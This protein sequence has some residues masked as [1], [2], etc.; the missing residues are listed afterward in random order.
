YGL[1]SES[2]Q[3]TVIAGFSALVS[4]FCYQLG[5]AVWAAGWTYLLLRRR[6]LPHVLIWSAFMVLSLALQYGSYRLNFENRTLIPSDITRVI[7]FFLLNVGAPLGVLNEPLSGMMGLVLLFTLLASIL[8]IRRNEAGLPFSRQLALALSLV[9]ISFVSSTLITLGRSQFGLDWAVQSRYTTV[10]SVGVLGIFMC[11]H[12]AHTCYSSR[13]TS[14]LVMLSSVA[15]VVG[16]GFSYVQG[17]SSGMYSWATRMMLRFTVQS[18]DFE[19]VDHRVIFHDLEVLQRRL[20]FLKKYRLGVYR[21]PPLILIP[22]Q[23]NAKPAPIISPSSSLVQTFRCPVKS[24]YDFKLPFATSGHKSTGTLQLV[25]RNG[26]ETVIS[27]AIPMEKIQ[28]NSWVTF[29]L[30]RPIDQCYGQELTLELSTRD[31]TA[32]NMVTLWTFPANYE[33]IRSQSSPG[34]Q[35]NYAIGLKLNYDYYRLPF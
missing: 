27:Q 4:M 5:I 30:P 6:A 8:T 25:L 29:S 21:E 1:S 15:I 33:V 34:I 9:A 12:L 26:E 22:K 31:A 19:F 32:E 16:V 24:L 20:A 3:G 11:L 14:T 18:M 28:P 2:I 35:G 13:F 7:V 23:V 17:I 10:T